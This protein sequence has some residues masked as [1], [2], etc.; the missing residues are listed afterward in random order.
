MEHQY[1]RT[2]KAR[3]VSASGSPANQASETAV[4]RQIVADEL[5][6]A[7]EWQISSLGTAQDCL[8]ARHQFKGIEG[9]L[10]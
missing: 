1:S 5:H 7:G 9:L 6:M 3:A 10:M 2:L 8:Y 4:N